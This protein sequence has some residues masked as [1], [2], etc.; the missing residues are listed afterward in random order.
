MV[1]LGY[2]STLPVTIEEMLHHTRAVRRGTRNALLVADMPY[3][4]YHAD[5]GG[6]GAQCGAVRERGGRGSRK[7]RRRRAAAGVDRAT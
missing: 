5:I 6:V 4:S 1:V 7:D 2:E 3:G